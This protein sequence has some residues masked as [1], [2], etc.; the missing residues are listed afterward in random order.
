MSST[1]SV[2]PH[3]LTFTRFI[4]QEESKYW[5]ATGEFTDLLISIQIVVKTVST[6]VRR[7]GLT[8]FG[9]SDA[10]TKE[11]KK[12]QALAN[13]IFINIL[14]ASGSVGIMISEENKHVIEVDKDKKGKYIVAFD[15][16]D[17]F[18][19]I[20]C[21]ISIG[22]IFAVM[23]K[24]NELIPTV[25]DALHP[26]NRI[27]AAGYALYGT[28]T[29]L[30]LSTGQGVNGFLLDPQIGEFL[31]TDKNIKVPKKGSI[32]SINE[33]YANQWEN[34]VKEFVLEKKFPPKGKPYS[35]R[36]V[37]SMV[38]DVHRTIKHGGIFMY[39]ANKD[40]P[41]GKLRVMYEC[42]PMAFVVSQAGGLAHTGS[43]NILD[44]KVESIH[45]RTPIFLGSK[46]DVEE[47]VAGFRKHS[48]TSK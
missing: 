9:T 16:L 38:A 28:S 31:L 13:E 40:T 44:V 23:V 14:T 3:C 39:P 32:Y 15:P 19:N 26:G 47:I 25:E 5:R 35:L 33:G 18:T 7:A 43:V 45:Q 6:A 29:M 10:K 24:D 4:L 27:I 8:L 36:Y 11:P 2:D 21:L 20:D 37:G 1:A 17:G 30:V 41:N 42:K 22:S 34:S 48:I 46:D 12:L